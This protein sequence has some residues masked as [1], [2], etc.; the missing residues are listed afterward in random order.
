MLYVRVWPSPLG[1]ILLASDGQALTG[2]WF[3]GQRY[4]AAGLTSSPVEV[5]LPVFEQAERWLAIYF[6]GRQPEFTPALGLGKTPYQRAVYDCL[7]RIPWGQTAT[8][9]LIAREAAARLG[10][11]PCARAAGGAISRNPVSIIVP[12]HRVLP[13]GGG[14]GGYAGGADRK[15]ALLALEGV[16]L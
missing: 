1:R 15:K 3:E 16:S 8:Y 14:L 11:R 4:F 5:P 10:Q 6:S 2:L 12:C 7:L 13:K 9:D